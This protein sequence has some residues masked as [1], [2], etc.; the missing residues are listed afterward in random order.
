[1]QFH[2]TLTHNLVSFSLLHL[3]LSR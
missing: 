1:M 3:M 2:S